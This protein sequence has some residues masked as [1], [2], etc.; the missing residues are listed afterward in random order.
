[1]DNHTVDV[2]LSSFPAC[3][4]DMATA[5]QVHGLINYLVEIKSNGV[6]TPYL[7]CPTYTFL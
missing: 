1:M 2:Y 6:H 3:T 7:S 4:F 5:E